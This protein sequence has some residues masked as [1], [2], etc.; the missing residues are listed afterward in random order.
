MVSEQAVVQPTQGLPLKPIVFYAAYTGLYPPSLARNVGLRRIKGNILFTLDADSIIHPETLRTCRR[1]IEKCHGKAFVRVRTSRANFP[2]ENPV[3]P[4]AARKDSYASGPGGCIA[5]PRSA[6]R[7]IHGWD[8]AFVGY[9]AAD[10]D[11]VKRLEKVGLKEVVLPHAG[12]PDILVLHQ[13]HPPNRMREHEAR[14]RNRRLYEQTLIQEN[15]VRNDDS[16]GRS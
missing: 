9:G 1:E 4:A 13:K 15:P 11:Y 7:K 5:A 16:W 14:Q 8:E 12:A 3:F 6:I 2:L 10:W